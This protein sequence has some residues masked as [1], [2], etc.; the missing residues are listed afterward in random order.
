[1]GSESGWSFVRTAAGGWMWKQALPGKQGISKHSCR[2][3][4]TLADCIG[5]AKLH[6][7]DENASRASSKQS[8]LFDDEN[9]IP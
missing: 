7:Y 2:T 6:G 1:M 4:E 5:D 3:F 9:R 8:T